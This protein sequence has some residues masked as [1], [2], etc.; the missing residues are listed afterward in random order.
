MYFYYVKKK[1]KQLY[2]NNDLIY[3]KDKRIEKCWNKK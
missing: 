1:N 3:L 2:Y